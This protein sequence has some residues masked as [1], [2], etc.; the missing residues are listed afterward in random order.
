M[1]V[2]HSR[3]T[4][5]PALLATFLVV[6]EEGRISAAAKRL[7]L[8]QPAVTAQMRKLEASLATPLLSRSVRGVVATAAGL[9]L[10]DYARA[11]ARLLHEA[12]AEIGDAED[13]LG[14]LVI[15]ASTT[16]AAHV[17]PP[18]LAQFR[19]YHPAVAIRI[20]AASSDEVLELIRTNRAPLGLVEGHARAAGLRLEPFMDDEIVAVVA[21]NSSARLRDLCDLGQ[22]PIVWR[23]AGSG[24]RQVVERAL[25]KAFRHAGLPN[26]RGT[27]DIELG[28]TEAVVAGAIAGLGVAFVSRWSIRAHL[29]ANLVRVVPGLELA[30]NRTFRW[31]LPSGGLRGAAAKFYALA[32]RSPS[33]ISWLN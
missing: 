3:S 4:L 12:A 8:S 31:A 13:T 17:V 25:A 7:H 30:I 10:A 16:I 1:R 33:S 20:M 32:Q 26:R 9:K 23:E 11:L 14:E 28:S 6:V 5:D 24:T 15:A 27:L 19:G 29:A 22:L 21:R 2:T 18:L